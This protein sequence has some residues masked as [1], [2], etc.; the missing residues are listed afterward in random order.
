MVFT[1]L[2]RSI[3]TRFLAAVI[4]ALVLSP[5][6]EP[7]ATI[8]GTDFGG[9]GAVDVGDASKL[10]A[11]ALDAL[12]PAAMILVPPSLPVTTHR[13]CPLAIALDARG[14]RRA[15]LRL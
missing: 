6:S 10:K 11:V 13:R 9:A 4:I 2:Y 14:G 5:Y 12:V 7:F 3:C 15:V 8:H 1:S